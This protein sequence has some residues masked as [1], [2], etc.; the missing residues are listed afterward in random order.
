MRLPV[1]VPV[2][3]V[4]SLRSGLLSLKRA[5]SLLPVSL[6]LP[7]SRK[8]L[9]RGGVVLGAA[10]PR[11]DRRLLQRLA[12]REGDRPRQVGVELV[13]SVEVVGRLLLVVLVESGLAWRA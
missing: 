4:T 5:L 6:P 9:E 1:P 13:H 10:H 11:H 12:V 3:V 2:A 7:L 8:P